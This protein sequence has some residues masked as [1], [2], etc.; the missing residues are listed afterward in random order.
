[1]LSPPLR[2][3]TTAG[4]ISDVRSVASEDG[5]ELAFL[6]ELPPFPY[7]F[8]NTNDQPYPPAQDHHIPIDKYDLQG[9]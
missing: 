4:D 6:D 1:L 8:A 7:V 3:I 2:N 9:R 5:T